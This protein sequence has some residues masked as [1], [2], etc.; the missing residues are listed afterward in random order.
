MI[1]LLNKIDIDISNLFNKSIIINYEKYIKDKI[2]NYFNNINYLEKISEIDIL[3]KKFKITKLNIIEDI[4]KEI[5]I[6]IIL[7]NKKAIILTENIS[8]KED[9]YSIEILIN[10]KYNKNI[11]IEDSSI[12]LLND[13]IDIINLWKYN[14]NNSSID[15]DY[16]ENC[17]KNPFTFFPYCINN[18]EIIK[19]VTGDIINKYNKLL[20][21]N[22]ISYLDL[23]YFFHTNIINNF[24][25]SNNIHNIIE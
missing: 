23:I 24:K 12:N 1:I 11:S 20:G 15:Y 8:I 21:F 18:G 14:I 13:N 16:Y 3:L 10:L 25:K 19:K 17:Y 6:E 2:I 22:K 9:K 4:K 7:P 5:E